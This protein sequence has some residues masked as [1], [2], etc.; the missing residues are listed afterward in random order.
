MPATHTHR[1]PSNPHHHRLREPCELFDQYG[2][3]P[4]RR[5]ARIGV[6]L[7]I[8]VS[9]AVVF[10]AAMFMVQRELA[11]PGERRLIYAITAS[12]PSI[13]VRLI[14]VVLIMFSTLRMFSVIHGSVVSQRCMAIMQEFI[15]V[16]IYISVGLTLLRKVKKLAVQAHGRG[17]E[18]NG[19]G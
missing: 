10:I 1:H 7:L 14:Y 18:M 16:I 3:D 19:T 12:I 9:A 4:I 8:A 15:V 11:E 17:K 2:T 5:T 13:L 6:I